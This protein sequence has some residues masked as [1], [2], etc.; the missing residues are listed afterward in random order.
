MNAAWHA[1]PTAPNDVFLL[2]HVLLDLFICDT[3]STES[4]SDFGTKYNTG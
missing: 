2:Q 3:S 1:Q 4:D